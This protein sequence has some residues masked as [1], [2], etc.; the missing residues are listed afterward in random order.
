MNKTTIALAIMKNKQA[1]EIAFKALK[2]DTLR[3]V[4]VKQVSRRLA[5]K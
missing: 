5:G 2:N 4:V 3:K 1:R